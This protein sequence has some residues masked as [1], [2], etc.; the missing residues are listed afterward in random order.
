MDRMPRVAEPDPPLRGR[1]VRVHGRAV[2]LHDHGEGEPVLLLHGNGSIGQEILSFLPPTPGVRWIAPDRPGYGF[3]ARL[4]RDRRDPPSL[5]DW[6]AALL[7][8]LRAPRVRVVAHSIAAGTAVHLAA[9]RPE[10]VERLVLLAPF[11][12]PTPHR[13][14]LPLRL[15]VA[16]VV[17]GPIR[18]RIAPFVARRWREALIAGMLAPQ[19]VPPWLRRFPVEHALRPGAI[20]TTADEL[21]AFN[22]GMRTLRPDVRLRPPVHVVVGDDDRTAVP[23]WHLPWLRARAP[24]MRLTRL[25]GVGHAVQH[26]APEAVRA[27]VLDGLGAAPLA[28]VG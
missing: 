7:D 4:P 11:C 20:V 3:S 9:R 10:R 15:A 27:V 12:R 25:P 1:R 16:P 13:L 17:G 14:M 28:A 23:E 19:P 5:A 2:H 6:C 8:A 22:D 18:A 24:R 21:L 26:A